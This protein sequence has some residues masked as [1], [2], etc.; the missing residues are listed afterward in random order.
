MKLFN[1]LDDLIK[2]RKIVW[3]LNLLL[4]NQKELLSILKYCLVKQN[5]KYNTNK[6]RI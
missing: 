2:W 1:V 5:V 6:Y 4:L 3:N